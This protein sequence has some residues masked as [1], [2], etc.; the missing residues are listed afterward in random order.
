VA[1]EEKLDDDSEDSD[2]EVRTVIKY[3]K[4]GNS[5]I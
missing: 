5:F 1:L 3:S 2:K 4:Q